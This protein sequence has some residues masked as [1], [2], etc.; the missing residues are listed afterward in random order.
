MANGNGLS[1]SWFRV[2]EQ[3]VWLCLA[4]SRLVDSRV[5]QLENIL[6]VSSLPFLC[7]LSRWSHVD[8][9]RTRTSF[10]PNP[11]IRTPADRRVY[12]KNIYVHKPKSILFILC[13]YVRKISYDDITSDAAEREREKDTKWRVIYTRYGLNENRS[14]IVIHNMYCVFLIVHKC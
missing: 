1:I 9:R 8:H 2:S 14:Q 7:V 10:E 13:R 5:N 6:L 11:V 12:S 3:C 4:R